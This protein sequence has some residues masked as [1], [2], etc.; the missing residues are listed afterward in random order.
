ML[1][2]TK[3]NSANSKAKH[4]K[5]GG[6]YLFYLES[7]S[8]RE[9]GDFDDYARGEHEQDAPAPFWSC[10]GS[11]LLGLEGIATQEQ[12]ERLARG[13]NPHTAEPMLRGSGDGHVMGVDMTFSAPKDVSI[14]FAGADDQTRQVIIEAMK[15]SVDAALGYTESISITRHGHAGRIKQHAEATIAS[16]YM[17]FAS[18]ALDPQLHVHAFLFN[19][20]KRQGSNEWSALDQKAQFDHKMAT[21]ML[22]RVELAS[23][24]RQ[25]GFQ[26]EAVGPY[27]N[28]VGIDDSQ[29]EAMSKRSQD[30]KAYL[31]QHGLSSD[32]PAAREVASLN[33]RSSKSE[34]VYAELLELFS[35]D[36]EALGITPAWVNGLRSK[37]LEADQLA[38]EDQSFTLD[39]GELLS[40]LLEKRSVITG[41]D[42]LQLIGQKSM[43]QWDANR[44][45][46]ELNRFMEHPEV[47]HLGQTEYLSLVISSHSMLRLE[48]D[49]SLAVSAGRE[50]KAH[51]AKPETVHEAFNALEA[52]LAAK[53]G[54]RVDLSQ[55]REA[56]LHVCSQTGDH[57]F[58]EGWAGAGKTTMLK[59]VNEIYE[60]SGFRVF[61][62]SQSASAALNLSR[63]SGIRSSTIASLLLSLQAGRI[64]LD[65]QS[66]L[67]LD[68]AGVVGSRE[69]SLLQQEVLKA[70]AKFVCVGDPKQL[71]PVEAGGI[72]GT[73]LERHGGAHISNIQRQ[74]TDIK[75]LIDWLANRQ[76]LVASLIT[77]ATA[78]TLH[79]LTDEAALSVIK[80][81]A[82]KNERLAYALE[83][84]RARFDQEWMREAIHELAEGDAHKALQKFDERGH[85]QLTSDGPQTMEAL[86]SA[87]GKDK[88]TLPDK[89]IIAGLRA[90]VKELNHRARSHLKTQGVISVEAV[91]VEVE[92][93]DG[94]QEERE[95]SVNDRIVFTKNDREL[96]VLNGMMGR[97]RSLHD[98]RMIVELDETNA[99][100]ESS[101]AI[102]FSFGFFDHAYCITNHKA[103]GRTVESAHVYVNGSLLDREW[104][105]VA[106]SRSRHATTLY[107]NLASLGLIDAESHLPDADAP[108]LREVYLNTLAGRM[109]NSR[110]KK[111]TLDYMA[112]LPASASQNAPPIKKRKPNII[113]TMKA[114]SEALHAIAARLIQA[115]QAPKARTANNEYE[116]EAEQG[117][118]R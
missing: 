12:V 10:S 58:V 13:L 91:H 27:F 11:A 3:I 18:R 107:A 105:Y 113:R 78:K 57:A 87:W 37:T 71:Q 41:Q 67:V 118:S 36:A 33:T 115:A 100:G 81:L 43:G 47:L 49:I 46:E 64:R 92:L 68:E 6:S 56:A 96:G 109:S 28:V 48:S 20:G 89:A 99:R 65:Q 4:A 111:T 30:I 66:V 70:G 84:W 39:A 82:E 103:Q 88:N 35:H 5:D 80:S 106:A 77:E 40:E 110:A 117:L 53:L 97:L 59:A 62:C 26:V 24:I 54:T 50:S 16:C 104:A 52:E 86:I 51:Q 21:G 101:V 63:E 95:L 1:S 69:F 93:R 83:K 14:L 72:F 60:Q 76:G 112:P 55:Q 7:P 102:P 2:I 29:R 75:P 108:K 38:H 90:D 74:R 42:A 61:G 8:T 22:F 17:H 34:P 23:R 15:A 25:L 85:L 98:G 79:K 19:L 45:R 73:L 114:I 9:R 31:E 32:D 44:C 94:T 116:L